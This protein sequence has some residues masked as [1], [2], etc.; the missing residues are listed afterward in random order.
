[1]SR[2]KIVTFNVNGIGG[3]NTKKRRTLFHFLHFHKIQIAILQETHSTANDELIWQAEWGGGKIFFNHG[4]SNSRGV[5]IL[6]TRNYIPIVHD[7][8]KDFAGRTLALLI[9]IEKQLYTV[10]SLYAP[11][12]DDPEFFVKAFRLIDSFGNDTK[13][14]MGDFNTVLNLQLDIKG[15][16]GH[17]NSNTRKILNDIIEQEELLDIW[18]VMNGTDFASTFSRN[19]PVILR[20]RLDYILI[21]AG[22]QQNVIST[23]IL[24][25][26]ISDHSPVLMVINFVGI[27][28]GKG[29]W[30][31]NN[32]LLQD[33]V[34]TERI[35]TAIKEIFYSHKKEDICIA[36]E[37][38]KM[39]VREC[40]VIRGRQLAKS[41]NLKVQALT[42]KLDTIVKEQNQ[43]N[44]TNNM[45]LFNDHKKQILEIKKELQELWQYKTAGA[46]LRCKVNWLEHAGKPSRY[47]L[48]L[49]KQ[50]Y[51]KKVITC[52][53]D[54]VSNRLVTDSKEILNVLNSYF[55]DLYSDKKLSLDLDYLG[56]LNTPQ[57]KDK[58]KAMLDAPIALEEI[59]MALKQLNLNKT[60]GCDGLTPEFYLKYWDL[61]GKALQILYKKISRTVIFILL[62]EMVS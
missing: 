30:K 22:L 57:V 4:T 21:S 29:Y 28:P 42:K 7:I 24:V 39:K 54:P 48:S 12:E 23:D 37:L 19:K 17:S 56:T 16:K 40:S 14:I 25:S 49:E 31:L 58:D 33:S 53:H 32:S 34:L 41:R 51:V 61:L 20:E 38:M 46:A 11:N 6:F 50:N 27:T 5:A 13:I 59:K 60:P 44:L 3:N 2:V 62:L 15:G 47:F 52:I 55:Q 9:E 8:A 35:C 36:W 10:V 1:M 26:F 45:P 18:R 43:L